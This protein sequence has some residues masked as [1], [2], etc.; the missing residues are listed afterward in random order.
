M[1][2]ENIFVRIQF[3]KLYFIHNRLRLAIHMPSEY[4]CRSI[5]KDDEVPL[6]KL[7]ETITS[8]KTKSEITNYND[9]VL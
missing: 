9:H 6:G 1:Y 7:T 3:M 8:Q 4:E 2:S 5:I